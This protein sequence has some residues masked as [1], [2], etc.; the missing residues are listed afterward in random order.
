MT[1]KKTGYHLKNTLINEDDVLNEYNQNYNWYKDTQIIEPSNGPFRK[2]EEEEKTFLR[3][4][5]Q[6]QIVHYHLVAS[7]VACEIVFSY[8]IFNK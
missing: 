8:P 3:A 7:A 6:L 4:M 2:I 5:L 1:L